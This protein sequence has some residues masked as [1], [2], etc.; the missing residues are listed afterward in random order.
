MI[1]NKLKIFK[2]STEL[3]DLDNGL[4]ETS[5]TLASGEDLLIGYYKPI[6]HLFF[7]FKTASASNAGLT[8]SKSNGTDYTEIEIEDETNGFTK[9]GHIFLDTLD[10][11]GAITENSKELF[12][13]KIENSAGAGTIE[14]RLLDIVFCNENDLKYQY[15]SVSRFYPEATSTPITYMVAATKQI[16][17]DINLTGKNK[18]NG[19]RYDSFNN[20]DIFDIEDVRDACAF[21]TMHLIYLSLMD[22]EDDGYENKAA[23]YL[24][25][26]NARFQIF[27]GSKLSVDSDDDGVEDEAENEEAFE[28]N[29]FYR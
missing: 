15:D 24:D 14:L 1:K 5:L 13:V 18:Y 17:S 9:S 3:L 20:W 26:Y 10:T 2:D 12:W 28:D 23:M 7:E 6:N 16:I 4:D 21:Y 25:K 11:N 22:S 27:S 8:I 19:L 29:L